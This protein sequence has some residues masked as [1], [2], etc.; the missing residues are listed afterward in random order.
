VSGEGVLAGEWIRGSRNCS[1]RH[2]RRSQR[3]PVR[4]CRCWRRG[5]ADLPPNQLAL[6][7]CTL[8]VLDRQVISGRTRSQ[9]DSRPTRSESPAS[10]PARASTVA[11]PGGRQ[12]VWVIA[13][14]TTTRSPSGL[15]RE[16]GGSLPDGQ[17]WRGRFS[18]WPSASTTWSTW[19]WQERQVGHGPRGHRGVELASWMAHV[20]PAKAL[21]TARRRPCTT[22][23]G[24]EPQD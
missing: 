7:V 8:E 4:R 22:P 16:A 20:V 9:H 19:R 17:S 1:R 18:G 21:C 14:F 11:A 5:H 3:G 15:P 13:S 24:R 10:R 2:P 6:C 23:T 12:Q